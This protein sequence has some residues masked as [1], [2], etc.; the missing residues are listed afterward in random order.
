MTETTTNSRRELISW[1][2][3]TFGILLSAL[4]YAIFIL[5][6]NLFEG[7]VTGIGIIVAKLIGNAF[8]AGKMPPIVG[9]IAWILTLA[10]F[11]VAVRVLGKS[12]GAKSLYATTLLYFSMDIILWLLQSSGYADRIRELLGHELLVAAIYGAI[13][14]GAG[15]AIVFNQGAATGGADALAQMVRKFK[16]IPV[17]KT[18]LAIDTVVLFIGFF[19]FA[20][21]MT[22]FKTMMYSFIF[23]VIQAKTLDTILNG[24][25][26]NNLV[27]IITGKPEEIKQ[28]I[29]A[30]LARGMTVY[31][32]Q[33]GYTGERRTTIYT[34]VSKRQVPTLRKLVA[35]AD[36]DSFVIVQATEQVYGNG[37]EKF[38]GL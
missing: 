25:S 6:L 2:L 20:D 24:F 7:G 28:A 15:M 33:G 11:A 26:A 1:L 31:Q 30:E 16:H 29:L 37:F 8:F 23:V 12:F 10:L 32:G 27:T 3:I 36:P 4:G 38:P 17:S 18:I 22:G 5:P 34:V 19:T 13:L 35:Q 21:M 9:V 14:I